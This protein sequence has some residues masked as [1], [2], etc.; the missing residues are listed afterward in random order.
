MGNGWQGKRR[1]KNG[2]RTDETGEKVRYMRGVKKKKGQ[3]KVYRM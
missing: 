2:F 1:V 3:N